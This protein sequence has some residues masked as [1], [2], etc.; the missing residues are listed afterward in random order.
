MKRIPIKA[1]IAIV[2]LLLASCGNFGKEVIKF[3]SIDK[4]TYEKLEKYKSAESA[5]KATGGADYPKPVD[6]WFDGTLSMQGFIQGGYDWHYLSALSW[7][8]EA[9]QKTWEVLDI[10]EYRYDISFSEDDMQSILEIVGGSVAADEAARMAMKL[11][12]DFT[13]KYDKK[14]FYTK[15]NYY[16]A[17]EFRILSEKEGVEGALLKYAAEKARTTEYKDM[18]TPLQGAIKMAN[19]EHFNVFTADLYEKNAGI[20]NIT[21]DLQSRF[22]GKG[23]TLSIVAVK[24]LFSGQVGSVGEENKTLFYGV[25][26]SL[27]IGSNPKP[28]PF[29]FLILGEQSDVSKY[30]EKLTSLLE[31]SIP[32]I[33]LEIQTF[34]KPEIY[35]V[36][37]AEK[38]KAALFDGGKEIEPDSTGIQY[39]IELDDRSS[40]KRADETMTLEVEFSA[41]MYNP[42]SLEISRQ[43]LRVSHE[44][45]AY[46]IQRQEKKGREEGAPSVLGSY[47]KGAYTYELQPAEGFELVKSTDMQEPEADTETAVYKISFEL[48]RPTE[49]GVYR[50]YVD[51]GLVLEENAFDIKTEGWVEEWDIRINEAES[52]EKNLDAFPGDRTLYLESFISTAIFKQNSNYRNIDKNFNLLKSYAVEIVAEY[53]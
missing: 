36:A 42:Y 35:E 19:P 15:G 27:S 4:F 39:K 18:L 22:L 30:S 24:S 46:R 25:D 52:W 16:N 29:Y 43:N 32:G 6:F 38:I 49:P 51:A 50:L 31:G 40:K 47:Q 34:L 33:E 14:N 7:L 12:Q 23:K 37:S 2:A 9:A 1:S 3:P 53:N 11:P 10:S 44:S 13:L 41:E 48:N 17:A 8:D 26:K 21:N 5:D 45:L 20:T 28:H